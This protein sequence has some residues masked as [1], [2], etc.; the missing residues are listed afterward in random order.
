MKD[1]VL[2]NITSIKECCR[3]LHGGSIGLERWSSNESR[4][5]RAE[6]ALRQSCESVEDDDIVNCTVV[7]SELGQETP[8]CEVV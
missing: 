7:R 2:R 4:S 5:R 6:N 3:E 8:I 1:S